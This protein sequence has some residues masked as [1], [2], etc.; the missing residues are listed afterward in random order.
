MLIIS[1]PASIPLGEPLPA[2]APDNVK[3]EA[4]PNPG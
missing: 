4:Y 3:N 2:M 1:A